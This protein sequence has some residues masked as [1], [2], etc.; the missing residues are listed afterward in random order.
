MPTKSP[1]C[2]NA[3]AIF[4]AVVDLPTPPLPEA[5]AITCLAGFKGGFRGAS[6]FE[7]GDGCDVLAA[8]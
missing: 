6:G 8:L 2:F 4:M 1:I 5:T 7:R 3:S